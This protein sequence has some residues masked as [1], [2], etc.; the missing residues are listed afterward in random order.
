MK[1]SIILLALFA[2]LPASA[3]ERVYDYVFF[4]NSAM[5]GNW[6][7]SKVSYS[8]G[9]WLKNLRSH[10]PVIPDA[11]SEGNSLELTFRSAAKGDWKALLQYNDIRG[12]EVLAVPGVLSLYVKG[13]APLPVAALVDKDGNLSREVD[14]QAYAGAAG[15]NGWRPVRVPVEAFGVDLTAGKRYGSDGIMEGRGRINSAVAVQLSSAGPAEGEQTLLVD[16]VEFLPACLPAPPTAAPRLVEAKGYERHIDL[17]WESDDAG[18]KYYRIYRSCD[19]KE[20][21]PVTVRQPG[22]GRHADYLGEVSRQAWYRVAA[23]GYDGQ[24]SPCSNSLCA[25]TRPMTDE[26]LLDMLQ[27]ANFRYYWE[28]CEPVSGLA[29]EDIPGRGDMIATGA[30]GFGMMAILTGIHRGFIS[31]EQGV[32]RFLRITDFLEKA[33]RHHGAY[34][35]FMDG[36]TGKTVPW[37]G[38]RDNGGDLVETA[39]LYQGLLAARQF[40]TGKSQDEKLIRTRIDHIWETTEWDWYRR[41]PDSPYLF[42][43]WSPDQEWVINHRLIGWNE[44]M[45][46]YLMAIMSPTHGVPAGMYYSGWA[47]QD[48]YA[49]EYR[50]GWGRVKDGN[51]YINGNTYFGLQLP[52]G[53]SNGGPLFFCHYSFMGFD[54]HALTDRYTN[55]FENNRTIARINLRYCEENPKGFA[56]YGSDCWGL[57]A[58]DHMWHYCASEPAEDLDD[59]TMAPT[60]ALASFPYTPEESMAAFKNYYRNYGHF[61]WGEYGFLDAFNLTE[62]WVAPIYMGLNQGPVTVMVENARSGFIWKLVMSHPDVQHGLKKLNSLR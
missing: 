56:G 16:D 35:H 54:P 27:E 3:T 15:K 25:Q 58:S 31:R 45:A 29:R 44:T 61:L 1:R 62:N 50:E 55:Y 2:C 33:E 49:A 41:T 18:V 48:E 32:E 30:S 5:E 40:F 46:V 26:E 20:Y 11:W 6:Y 28:G 21:I 13:N 51:R 8:G 57:T 53:V 36:P 17:R 24:E 43:H 37:F 14:L 9:G 47:S 22:T 4:R 23:V 59:G 10:L 52:V 34:S 42:W 60:G 38:K 7:Y 19:G 39:F 12:V